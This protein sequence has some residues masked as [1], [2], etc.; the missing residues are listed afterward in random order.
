MA[1][2]IAPPTT[3]MSV[4]KQI[5]EGIQGPGGYMDQVK[6]TTAKLYGKLDTL[7]GPDAPVPVTNT[8]QFLDKLAKGK[9][10]AENI[11]KTLQNAKVIDLKGALEADL[12]GTARSRDGR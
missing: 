3:K 10:G 5:E 9:P 12:G 1:S 11:L 4:G 8:Q 6:A 7:M 2:S